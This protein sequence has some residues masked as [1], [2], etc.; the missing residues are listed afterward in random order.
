MLNQVFC[1]LIVRYAKIAAFQEAIKILRR[2]GPENFEQVC[3][4][5]IDSYEYFA[6]QSPFYYDFVKNEIL[7]KEDLKRKT[8]LDF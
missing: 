2:H 1:K 8:P 3:K 7:V 6:D 4:E 5:K